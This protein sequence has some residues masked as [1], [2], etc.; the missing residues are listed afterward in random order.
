MLKKIFSPAIFNF[1]LFIAFALGIII[2]FYCPYFWVFIPLFLFSVALIFIF[3]NRQK[4]LFSDI[5]IIILF[6]SLG[7]LWYLPFCYQDIDSFLG[8]ENNFVIQVSS[9]PKEAVSRNVFLADIKKVN[10]SNIAQRARVIDYSKKMDYLNDY[11]VRAKLSKTT[12]KNKDFYTLW[13]KSNQPPEKLPSA[14]LDKFNRKMTFRLIG[15]LK[16][17]LSDESYRFIAS[18]FLGRR[19]L[20]TNEEKN[21]FT[22]AG[23]SHLLAISGSN[24]GLTALVLFFVF[25]LFN[26][27][28]RMCL[29]L[30]VFFLFIYTLI[31]GAN[32]PTLRAIIMYTAFSLSFFVKRKLNP[33]NSL[34]LAG[35]A[36]LIFNPSWIFDVGFQ[37]SFLSIFALILGFKIFPVKQSDTEFLNQLQY[38]FFSSLYVTLLITPLISYYFGR[39]YILSIFNNMLLIPF[40]TFILIV[41]F[42]LLIFS[43]FRFL[44]QSI[45][46]VVSALIPLFY[47][48][49]H[50]L[51]SI[52]FSFIACK[53]SLK[54]IFIYYIFI[55]GFIF[56]LKILRHRRRLQTV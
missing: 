34:G 51:G 5:F 24:I 31:T 2:G 19:E 23:I 53:F 6:L 10:G 56:L 16:N 43:P 39:I 22:D 55:V 49:S 9:M 4:F 41:N 11:K 7:A 25:K 48:L 21:I 50:F 14:F 32:P 18:V 20:L 36:C 44:A 52:K 26:V 3:S 1:W 54:T 15:I 17:N 13:V 46:A 42:T 35:L 47:K 37:L 40:F 33:F 38:L 27:R 29:L 30:S 45:A 12:I 28:F 8:N